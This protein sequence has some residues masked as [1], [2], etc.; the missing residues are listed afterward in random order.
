MLSRACREWINPPGRAKTRQHISHGDGMGAR[1]EQ[2]SGRLLRQGGGQA[3]VV[4]ESGPPERLLVAPR[5]PR[6]P[7]F[8]NRFLS[9]G[10]PERQ[11]Q[12]P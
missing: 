4:V 5:H 10:T 11:D 2:K 9:L 7:A 3:F 1:L 8:L 6:T 12:D